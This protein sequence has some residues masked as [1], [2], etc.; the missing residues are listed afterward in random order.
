MGWDVKQQFEHF[1]TILP[2][3]KKRTY[4]ENAVS[5]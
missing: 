4:S 5:P 1:T 3:N 2:P